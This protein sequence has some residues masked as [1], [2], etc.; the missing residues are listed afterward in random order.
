M[1][2]SVIPDATILLFLRPRAGVAAAP[3]GAAA[4]ARRVRQIGARFATAA[5]AMRS[6]SRARRRRRRAGS[7]SP[8]SAIGP[9]ARPGGQLHVRL[10]REKRQG[11]A[12]LLRI[13]GRSFQL[14]GG[15]RDAWA[16]DARADAEIQAAMRTGIELVVETRSSRG[17]AGPRPSTGCAAPPPRWTPPPS[18]AP[19]RREPACSRVLHRPPRRDRVQRG[20]ADAGRRA[21]TRR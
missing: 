6:P 15:G 4:V 10:S 12:V 20:G 16:P 8:R 13:D 18:P 7:P 19:A 21:R 17:P 3:A 9:G 11:S 14:I 2:R 5:A 1:M